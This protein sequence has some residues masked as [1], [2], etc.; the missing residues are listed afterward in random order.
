MSLWIPISSTVD[1]FRENVRSSVFQH[2]AHSITDAAKENY[3]NKMLDCCER[4][5]QVGYGIRGTQ[6]YLNMPNSQRI[7]SGRMLQFLITYDI[8]LPLLY[9]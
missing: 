4:G 6:D 8:Q 7:N 9:Q 5:I 3:V 2:W 1:I